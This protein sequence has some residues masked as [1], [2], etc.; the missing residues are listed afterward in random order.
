MENI[1]VSFSIYVCTLKIKYVLYKNID[2][3]YGRIFL[4]PLNFSCYF[5]FS[6]ILGFLKEGN[7]L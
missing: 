7:C 6:V 5:N 3:F 4:L 2:K 1:N